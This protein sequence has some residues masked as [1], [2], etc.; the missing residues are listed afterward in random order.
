MKTLFTLS[1]L[2]LRFFAS[3]VN[4][5]TVDDDKKE[6][7]N[8]IA[9]HTRLVVASPHYTYNHLE[10]INYDYSDLKALNIG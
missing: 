9:L 6:L 10:R 3:I 1:L 2:L 5:Q 4:G 7:G 8:P